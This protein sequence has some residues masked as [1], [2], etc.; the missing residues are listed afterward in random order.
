MPRIQFKDLRIHTVSNASGIFFGSNWNGSSKQAAKRNQSFGTVNGKLCRI[1][2]FR[3]SLEDRDRL[4]FHS[5][6]KPSAKM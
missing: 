3:A 6:V 1:S 2:D 5:A 4:D